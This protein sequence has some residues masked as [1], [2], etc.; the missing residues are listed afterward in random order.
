MYTPSLRQTAPPG[1]PPQKITL[2]ELSHRQN[3]ILQTL[4]DFTAIHAKEVLVRDIFLRNLL[5]ADDLTIRALDFGQSW[6]LPLDHTGELHDEDN[7]TEMAEV[8]N[9]TNVIYSLLRWEKFEL[10]II[11][12]DEWPDAKEL[13]STEGLP[14]RNV[15]IGAWSRQFRTLDELRQAVVSAM[16]KKVTP[17]EIMPDELVASQEIIRASK[18]S[19]NYT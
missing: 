17:K 13:P 7:Y 10:E 1:H 3:W 11:S 8:F 12:M 2:L 19:V 14:L 18:R 5:L 16:S 4:D 6:L 15:V 9:V